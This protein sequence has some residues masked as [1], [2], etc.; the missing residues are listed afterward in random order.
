MR[1][2]KW[3][4][5]CKG[6]G[7]WT[8]LKIHLYLPFFHGDPHA[9]DAGN[10]TPCSHITIRTSLKHSYSTTTHHQNQERT[11]SHFISRQEAFLLSSTAISSPP[12]DFFVAA[13]S[14][15]RRRFS[16]TTRMGDAARKKMRRPQ[17]L[18]MKQERPCF[19]S[20]DQEQLCNT[21]VKSKATSRN[22]LSVVLGWC[23]RLLWQ[24][25]T[26]IHHQ[27]DQSAGSSRVK[28]RRSK[29]ERREHGRHWTVSFNHSSPRSFLLSNTCSSDSSRFM[30]KWAL[31]AS[32]KPWHRD[33]LAHRWSRHA[34]RQFLL[35]EEGQ[36]FGL[37]RWEAIAIRLEWRPLLLGW[38]PLLAG[39]RPSLLG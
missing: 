23:L 37:G 8:H 34:Q 29:L 20:A 18:R 31:L 38:R 16:Q 10:Y 15:I 3:F 4:K 7:S 36:W 26:E 22:R 24:H 9:L 39:W 1:C 19:W 28:N 13:A 32:C 11:P 2:W 12:R 5:R 17:S 30:M 33:G 25:P 35:S 21:G 27:P 14:D 6:L